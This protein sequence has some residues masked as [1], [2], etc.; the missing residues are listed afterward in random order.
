MKMLQLMR[1]MSNY[2][3]SMCYGCSLYMLLLITTKYKQL[4]VSKLITK[5][6]L[7]HAN[8]NEVEQQISLL[9]SKRIIN[10]LYLDYVIL[11]LKITLKITG[12]LAVCYKNI[13]RLCMSTKEG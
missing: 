13:K 6:K 10:D 9:E 3:F 11:S 4:F 8:I 1:K 2:N 7:I 5:I 12:L